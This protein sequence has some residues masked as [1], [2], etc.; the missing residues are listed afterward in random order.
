MLGKSLE[1]CKDPAGKE[2]RK[3][4]NF[5]DLGIYQKKI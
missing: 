1:S 4:E 3:E 2:K 5:V